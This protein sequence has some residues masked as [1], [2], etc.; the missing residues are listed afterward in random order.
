MFVS[1]L[2]SNSNYAGEYRLF[3]FFLLLILI[4]TNPCLTR[5]QVNSLE[6]TP[7]EPKP[8]DMLLIVINANPMEKVEV[9]LTF[10]GYLN[11]SNNEFL[12]T[13]EHLEVPHNITEFQVE[14][15]NVEFLR[16]AVIIN[17]IP[18]TQ[19]IESTDGLATITRNDINPGNYWVQISGI[20]KNGFKEINFN[21]NAKTTITTDSQGKYTTTY[22]I[23]SF[24]TGEIIVKAD[25]L[26][27][28]IKLKNKKP[29]PTHNLVI[30]PFSIPDKFVKGNQIELIYKIINFGNDVS[31]FFIQFSVDDEIVDQY[32]INVLLANET[33]LYHVYWTPKTSGQ[34]VLQT[35]ID[36]TN[37]IKETEELDNISKQIIEVEE[38]MNLLRYL[39]LSLPILIASYIF[40]RYSRK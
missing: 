7:T 32:E 16:L 11:V 24:P 20:P 27:Q 39:I 13:I 26:T 23:T 29:T 35:V 2:Y 4:L 1:N 17:E 31:E 37:Q 9:I 34:K 12:Y 21:I 25:S 40:I 6:I 8:G 14:A 18:I 28:K 38:N 33:R 15:E 22:N 36:S 19:T 30:E 10:K 3:E 5:A